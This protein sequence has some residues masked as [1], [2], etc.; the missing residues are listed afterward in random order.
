MG[1]V[2]FLEFRRYTYTIRD[3]RDG[4][5]HHQFLV[6]CQQRQDL[7]TIN[8][9]MGVA[10]QRPCQ[11]RGCSRRRRGGKVDSRDLSRVNRLAA[12]AIWKAVGAQ[13]LRPYLQDPTA[14]TCCTRPSGVAYYERNDTSDSA[15]TP[16]K[17]A[18]EKHATGAPRVD[19]SSRNHRPAIRSALLG[20]RTPTPDSVAGT[21]RSPPYS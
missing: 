19:I 11:A 3:G 2:A 6:R 17:P 13:V 1:S 9:G 21:N 4:S 20:S 18:R 10:W 16:G 8:E 7:N 15:I 12:V 14:Q 5:T